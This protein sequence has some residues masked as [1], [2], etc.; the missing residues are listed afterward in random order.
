MGVMV[1]AL[2]AIAKTTPASDDRD[3]A[4]NLMAEGSFSSSIAS[5]PT[6]CSSA[7]LYSAA[8]S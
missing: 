5:M 1:A 4:A 8:A 7:F 3:R 2:A 6:T